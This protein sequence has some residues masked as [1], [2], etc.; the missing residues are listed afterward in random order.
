[1]GRRHLRAYAALRAVGADE[2]EL[3]AVCDPRL[4]AAEEAAGLA[5]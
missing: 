3:A 4:G 1:M 5:E 2:F